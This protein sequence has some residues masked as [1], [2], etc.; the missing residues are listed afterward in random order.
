MKKIL[1]LSLLGI[2]F[3][4]VS[5]AHSEGLSFEK[6]VGEYLFDIGYSS[7]LSAND[8]IRFDLSI[9]DALTKELIPFS[10]AWVRITKGEE[11]LFAGPIGY[12]E[13]GKPGFSIVFPYEG[14]Y[15]LSVRFEKG[16]DTIS[17]ASFSLKVAPGES[18]NESVTPIIVALI[19]VFIGVLATL[20][21]KKTYA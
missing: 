3:P 4:F 21:F 9:A 14:D 16:S 19:G 10:S 18:E 7:E 12:G 13:F 2:C 6:V 8:L 15:E 5:F 20:A 17:R 1:L 11:T